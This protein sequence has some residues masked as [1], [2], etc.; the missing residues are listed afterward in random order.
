MG[1][2]ILLHFNCENEITAVGTGYTLINRFKQLMLFH[3]EIL[4]RKEASCDNVRRKGYSHE[5]IFPHM[6]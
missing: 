3:S 1:G 5:I 4:F 2:F 6:D